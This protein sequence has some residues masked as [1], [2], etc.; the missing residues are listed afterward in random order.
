MDLIGQTMPRGF[1]GGIPRKGDNF[2]QD[3]AIRLLEIV[4]MSPTPGYKANF[5]F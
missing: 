5:L 3:G 4:D 1:G 2:G